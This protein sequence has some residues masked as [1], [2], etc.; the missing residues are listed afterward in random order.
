MKR[1]AILLTWPP[2]RVSPSRGVSYWS[3]VT[4]VS[5]ACLWARAAR[6]MPGLGK[7]RH[8]EEEAPVQVRDGV[9]MNHFKQEL[10]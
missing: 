10:P 2:S 7:E 1:A 6:E 8:R 9:P 3:D 5:Q 4:Q